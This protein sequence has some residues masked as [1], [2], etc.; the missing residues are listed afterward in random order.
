MQ[1]EQ[2]PGPKPDELQEQ[3]LAESAPAVSSPKVVPP[4]KVSFLKELFS[5]LALWD[6]L[7]IFIPVA[8]YAASLHRDDLSVLVF[9]SS[10]AGIIPLAGWM[11]KATEHLADK[12][13]DAVGGLLNATFGNACEFII[14]LAAIRAGPNYYDIVKA[15]IT[16]SIIG[17]VL[18][19]LGAS[20]IAGGM[21]YPVQTFNRTTAMTSAT[22]LAL[23][24]VSLI[25]PAIFHHFSKA[26]NNEDELAFGISLVLFSVYIL[27]LVFSLKTHK[28]LHNR[29]GN[30]GA[31]VDEALGTSGWSIKKSCIVLFVATVLVAVLSE[32]LVHAVDKC[33]EA[34]GMNKIFIGVILVAIVGNAA[35]HSTAIFMA[36]KD[37]MDLAMNIALGSGAQIA[38]LVAPTLVFLSFLIH[39][40]HPMDLRFSEF[41]VLSV[42]ASVIVL[43]YVASDGECNWLEGVQL[44]A[45]YA[46]LGTAFYYMS[47]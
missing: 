24:A 22:L 25:V 17:N 47:P 6:V 18:L 38:L 23:A 42:V 26:T 32:L 10:C 2:N 37:K 34:L 44:L 33:A 45:V 28:N 21:K 9:F 8:V 31:V 4:Q 14:A 20:M 16:G 1:N 12:K 15:S 27:S 30:E 43:Q 46:I 3:I 35:E 39:P 11:G 41:E 13:G 40:S 29:P 5:S 7:L 19:V 36:M